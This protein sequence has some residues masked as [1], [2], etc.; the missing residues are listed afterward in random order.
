MPAER[1]QLSLALGLS[2]GVNLGLFLF[3][4]WAMAVTQ[5]LNGRTP[6]PVRDFAAL[7]TDPSDLPEVVSLVL[8][9]EPESPD[10]RKRQMISSPEDQS[11]DAPADPATRFISSANMR[12]A[13]EEA[14][15]PDGIA[16]LV[17]QKGL[18]K[19]FL[20]LRDSE[21]R[22]GERE[23]SRPSEP[24]P[25]LANPSTPPSPANPTPSQPPPQDTPPASSK[26]TPEEPFPAE[27]P[28]DMQE[29]PPEP[30]PPSPDSDAPIR[31]SGPAPSAFRDHTSQTLIP[32]PPVDSL[33]KFRQSARPPAPPKSAPVPLT[34]IPDRVPEGYQPGMKKARIKGDISNRGRSSVDAVATAEG[35]FGKLI[36]TAIEKGWRRRM[37][38]LSGLANPGLV[39][40]EFEVDPKGRISNVKLANPGEANPVMQ[41]CALSAVIE[42]KLPPPPQELFEELQDNLTGGRMRCSFSFLIY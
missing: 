18:D 34:R 22:D 9:P 27:K 33:P 19:P 14:A 41:D 35:R 1:S 39:E 2:A 38:G 4:A 40:V 37:L 29:T 31:K 12:A 11:D 10:A 23:A 20:D 16:G 15:S 24:L 17:T 6:V 21:F 7:P 32:P 36:R 28:E 8:S 3:I 5:G 30:E 26:A 13:S 25:P 42:A